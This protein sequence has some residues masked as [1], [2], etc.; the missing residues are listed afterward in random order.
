MVVD[1][2]NRLCIMDTL[3]YCRFYRDLTQWPYLTDVVNAVTGLQLSV[4]ELSAV[5][6]RIVGETHEFN[7]RRGFGHD[8]ERLPRWLTDHPLPLADG[9]ECSISALE[10]EGM[11][12]DY[13]AE[14]GWGTP[15]A[16]DSHV[17]V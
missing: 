6:N 2:E 10:V 8:K 15:P 5:A 17:A 14:R 1:W 3:I 11:R 16:E 12:R 4:E 9:E 7:R 13:Y